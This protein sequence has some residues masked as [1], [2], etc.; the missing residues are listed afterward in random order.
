MADKLARMSASKDLTTVIGERTAKLMTPI[1]SKTPGRMIEKTCSDD[2]L[3][4]GSTATPR[5]TTEVTMT[6]I[7]TKAAPVSRAT[8]VA[9]LTEARALRQ[10]HDITMQTQWE[11]D[12]DCT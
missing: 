9:R 4:D 6:I 2:P 11:G 8:F 3:N 5:K 12:C 1:A 7:E 10:L